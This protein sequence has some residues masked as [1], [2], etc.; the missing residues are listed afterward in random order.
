M[1]TPSPSFQGTLTLITS[2]TGNGLSDLTAN[3][4]ATGP[5]TSTSITSPRGVC[6]DTVGNIYFSDN[7][8][9][10]IRKIS[11]PGNIISLVAGTGASVSGADGVA[12]SSSINAPFQVVLVPG[13]LLVYAEQSGGRVRQINLIA[14]NTT[15][16]AGSVTDTSSPGDGG[17]ITS[18]KFNVPVGVFQDS[19]STGGNCCDDGA[20]TSAT[21][22]GPYGLTG[23]TDKSLYV[24]DSGNNRVRKQDVTTGLSVSYIGN[25]NSADIV[26]VGDGGD[27]MLA[28]FKTPNGNFVDTMG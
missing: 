1:P 16:L 25:G 17:Q 15:T 23:D 8:Q 21:L 20:G 4:Y 7:G 5:A 24:A 28:R 18:A 3:V 27:P 6:T 9:F 13:S 26:N 14:G 22:V 19:S 10:T 2:V 12:T 11:A